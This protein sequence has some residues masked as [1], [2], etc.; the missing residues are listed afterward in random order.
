MSGGGSQS[1]KITES[2]RSD[3]AI[4]QNKLESVANQAAVTFLDLLCAFEE[5]A[6]PH[7]HKSSY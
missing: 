7:R 1:L 5:V 4:D 2:V 3:I 6:Y